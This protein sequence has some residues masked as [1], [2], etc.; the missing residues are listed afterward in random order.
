MASTRYGSAQF[1]SKRGKL[2]STR[3]RRPYTA[4]QWLVILSSIAKPNGSDSLALHLNCREGVSWR[5]S[6]LFDERQSMRNG[7]REDV[8]VQHDDDCNDRAQSNRMPD[9]ETED[10]PF[11]AHLC[12][13]R[14]RD[15][16]RLRVDHFAHH[17]A[18]AVGGAHQHWIDPQ[19]LRRDPLEASEQCIGRCIA[20]RERHTEPAE[21]RAK[22]WIK[23]ACASEGEAED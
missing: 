21:E 9:H 22:K 5:R 10:G 2:T 15:R 18:R 12:G 6:R 1:N 20:S 3:L 16:D 19:L 8:G 17:A 4:C 23:P 13:R 14:C 11:I 7:T